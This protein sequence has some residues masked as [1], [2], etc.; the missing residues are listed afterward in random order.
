MK[1]D[2]RGTPTRKHMGSR[3]KG[4]AHCTVDRNFD[5]TNGPHRRW[6]GLAYSLA[7]SR[8]AFL[9]AFDN[10]TNPVEQPAEEVAGAILA[11]QS[12]DG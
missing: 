9:R 1:Q 4:L 12:G 11:A 10:D 8:I 3:L 2:C 7:N 5:S 6:S